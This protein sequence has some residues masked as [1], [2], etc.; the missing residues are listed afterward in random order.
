MVLSISQLTLILCI[1][2]PIYAP[3]YFLKH[4]V[5]PSCSTYLHCITSYKTV[6][7]ECDQ[8][9]C[10]EEVTHDR[11]VESHSS[12]YHLRAEGTDV[13]DQHCRPV[14]IVEQP[15]QW[16]ALQHPVSTD[17]SREREGRREVISPPAAV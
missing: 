7:A 15:S 8:S 6:T 16:N 11:Q 5:C 17:L 14:H 13:G 1:L 12:S 10:L 9:G 2:A 4:W 3:V